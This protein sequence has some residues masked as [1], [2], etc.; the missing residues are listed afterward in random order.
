[1]ANHGSVEASLTAKQPERFEPYFLQRDWGEEWVIASTPQYLGKLIKMRAGA[2]GGFQLHVD[3]DE[4][5]HLLTGLAIVRFDNGVGGFSE[6]IINPGETYR[7][8][9]GTP[10]QFEAVIDCVIIETSTPHFEDR[11][12]LESNY[13]LPEAGGLPTTR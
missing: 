8:P 4:S 6:Q 5:E 12:R 13:G 7:I 1:M 11:V 10:H 9:P 3:K 2:K